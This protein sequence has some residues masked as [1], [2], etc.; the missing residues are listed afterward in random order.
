MLNTFDSNVSVIIATFN[1]CKSLKD[2][3]ESL[4]NQECN[5][6]FG[7]EVVVVDN[8]SKDKTKEAVESYVLP[9]NGRLR[10]LFEPRQGKSYALNAGIKEAE[11]EII[12]FI[13]DDC[14]AEKKWLL[15]MLKCFRIYNC[16]GIGGRVLPL[17]QDNT[18]LWIKENKDILNGPI[19]LY[20]YGED[21]R[22]YDKQNM[23]PFIG[24]NMILKKYCFNKAG[25]FRED[26]G[27]GLGSAG[28]DTEFFRRLQRNGIN[29]YYCGTALVL[30][31]IEHNR[32]NLEYIAKWCMHSGSY[33]AVKEYIEEK[34]NL[35]FCFGIP[36]YLIRTVAQDLF[37]LPFLIFNRREFIK[38]YMKFY[39]EIGMIKSYKKLQDK[40]IAPILINGKHS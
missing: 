32:M 15:N 20:D 6:S 24:A 11:G 37:L 12:A 30:H 23:L 21:I 14:L 16:D 19:P 18:P 38:L 33:Y 39:R 4:I 35:I 9:F 8:N 27:A 10:Y 26:L 40:I 2:T 28:E 25:L 29:L 17:Y 22:E 5:G 7:Y 1:R 36:R 13:D 34:N 31:K 3:L